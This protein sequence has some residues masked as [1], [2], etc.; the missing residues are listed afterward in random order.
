MEILITIDNYEEKMGSDELLLTDAEKEEITKDIDLNYNIEC[1][2]YRNIGVGAD[3]IVLLIIFTWA[4]F[5]IIKSGKNIN[6]GI[7]GWI[8]I[9]KKLKKLVKRNKVVS[10]DSEGA[11]LLALEM[12]HQKEKITTIEITHESTINLVDVSGFL[13]RNKG[14]AAKPF[15]YF[16]KAIT[17]NYETIYIIGVNSNGVANIIKRYD[18][19]NGIFYMEECED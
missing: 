19:R 14:L 10:V 18:I 6:D 17:V 9:G 4:G 3:W 5:K 11:T 8:E 16:V 7:N 12:I 15:N 2:E 13:P 1:I